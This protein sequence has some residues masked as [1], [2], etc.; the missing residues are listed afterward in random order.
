MAMGRVIRARRMG[1]PLVPAAVYDA[2]LEAA[3]IRRRAHEDAAE[4]RRQAHAEGYA[5]GNAEAAQ[6][7][8]HLATHE[9]ELSRRSERDALQASLLVA[10]QLLGAE[11][12]AEPERILALL[13][14]HLA[15][16]RR[17]QRLVLH[18][19]PQDVAWL[20]RHPAA[21]AALREQHTLARSLELR[22]D[23]SLTRGGCVIESNL[24]ELD[25][26][27]ETRLSMIAAALQLPAPAP[28]RSAAAAPGPEDSPVT[29]ERGD[30]E[31]SP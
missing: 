26:R 5:A 27:V 3:E 14:P 25:A 24:G 31:G 19:H 2:Q 10:G 28:D 9:A 20:E 8:L 15:R 7:L 12:A 11:L 18:L 16:M 22:A 21:L 1:K 29:P 30:T 4:I 17:A 13:R 6:K 23:P